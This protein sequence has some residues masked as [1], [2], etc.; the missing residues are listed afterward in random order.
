MVRTAVGAAV[1]EVV[2]IAMIASTTTEEEIEINR[3]STTAV[4]A[5]H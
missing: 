4:A 5:I 2:A 1:A 3:I